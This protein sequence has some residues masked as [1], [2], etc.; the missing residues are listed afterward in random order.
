MAN[1]A[2]PGTRKAR[3]VIPGE[4]HRHALLATITDA[5]TELKACEV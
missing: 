3:A 1:K 5:Q 2:L 4:P